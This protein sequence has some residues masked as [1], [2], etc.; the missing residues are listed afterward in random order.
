MKTPR[1]DVAIVGARC[2]GAALAAFLARRGAR[3]V[4][5]ERAPLHSEHVLSTHQ[6]HPPGI[7]VLDELGVGDAVRAVAPGAD[8]VRLAKDDADIDIRLPDGLTER[9]PRR[10]RLDGLLQDAA[11]EAGAELRERCTVTGVAMR[12]GRARGVRFE[13]PNGVEETLEAD[14][15][16]G[17]DGRHST[18]AA[19]VEAE[20]YLGYDAPRA[21]YWTYF[22]APPLWSDDA[23]YPFG[24]YVGRRGASI[25]TVF[26]TDHDQLLL[27]SVPPLAEVERSWRGD[28]EGTLL[29]DL[30]GDPVVGPLVE[31]AGPPLEPV[32]AT[33]RER[34]FFRRA[35]GPGWLLVGDA[36]HHK[37][38]VLGDG[39][40]EAL[41][42]A[43]SAAG[44]IAEGGDRALERW[45]RERDVEALPLYFLGRDE[46]SPEP[47]PELR[48]VVMRQ[49]ARRRDLRQ[50]MFRSVNRE[51]PAD[52]V[53]SPLQ[54]LGWALRAALSGRF[55]VLGDFVTMARQGARDSAEIGR[56]RRLLERLEPS[57]A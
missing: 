25:R 42:Q 1:Y 52:Q 55:G 15:V 7:R 4:V 35:A 16:V 53:F 50:R 26:H 8:V 12:D 19:C 43:R 9:C 28:P 5:L 3:V 37:D 21:L 56:R 24:M 49:V 23:A 39:I 40:S 18:V 47:F 27:G 2:A 6:I 14:L 46:G 51:L 32:R 29:A 34:Y 33:F 44:V 11:V 45:W 48:R 10:D 30:R 22:Q 31:A 36:G 38:F 57:R 20:E 13:G 54:I 17:A 41:V